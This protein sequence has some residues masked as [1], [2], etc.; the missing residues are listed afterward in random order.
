MK[1]QRQYERG[2]QRILTESEICAANR[3][4]FRQF[5]EFEEYKL[6]RANRLSA[7]D[8]S[9]YKTLYGYVHKFRNLNRWLNNKPWVDLTS[10]DIKR[11]Y[12][13]LEDGK[14]LNT[15]G[16][17]VQDK[18]SYYNKIMKSKPFRLVGKSEMAKNVIEFST[19][20]ARSVHYVTEVTF[21]K[22]VSVIAHPRHLLL[23]WLA[24]DIGENI[25]ALLQLTPNDFMRRQNPHTNE[26]EYLVNLPKEKIKR[27]RQSRS[28][29]TLYPETVR[30]LDIV[31]AQTA[32][33]TPVFPFEH[34]SALKFLHTAGRKVGA[35]CE[36]DG[37]RVSWKD[38]RSGMA[39]HLLS[40]GW[41]REEVDARLG[42]TPN[43]SALNA[44]INYLA[45]NRSKPKQRLHES[46]VSALQQ[47][48]E[49]LKRELKLA[50]SRVRSGESQ[51]AAVC[52]DI[53][54]F[55]REMQEIRTILSHV[56]QLVA[57]VPRAA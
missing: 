42:H 7:L 39:C 10:E 25:G 8:E 13:D 27:S 2:K 32:P 5:F 11:F 29:P 52:S 34:R 4:L 45:I 21:R 15:R 43:S 18:A 23:C 28:E 35:V 12:D 50:G 37:S 46:N 55:R 20:P 24:W 3:D 9:C 48:I 56:M 31:L 22:I 44:Y 41:S 47:E 30:Y 40:S 51:Q 19:A 38:L 57:T 54:Q 16:L 36:P 1:F 14:I 6:K 17:P 53:E 26:P 49:T 33:D